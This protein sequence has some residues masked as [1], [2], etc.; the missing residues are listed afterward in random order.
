MLQEWSWTE[1]FSAT[2]KEPK[3]KASIRVEKRRRRWRIG[4]MNL[5]TIIELKKIEN[6]GND[7][8]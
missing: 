4:E 6:D 7:D 8:R 3:E 1:K 2:L 5:E